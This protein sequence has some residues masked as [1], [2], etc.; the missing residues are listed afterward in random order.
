MWTTFTNWITADTEALLR[1]LEVSDE[2]PRS[3]INDYFMRQIDQ[4]RHHVPPDL[5]RE[6]ER[7]RNFDIVAYVGKSLRNAGFQDAD[8][9][10][11]T[12]DVIVRLL[13]DPGNLVRGWRGQPFLPRTK[14]AIRNAV[15]NLVEKRQRRRRWFPH[16]T[17]EDMDVALH[18]APDGDD[19]TIERFR[20]EV[21]D[22]L[23][24]LALAVLDARLD[25]VDVKSLVGMPELFTPS[26][27]QIKKSVQQVK[28][29]AASFGDDTFR[30]RV[31]KALADEQ[32]TLAKRFGAAAMA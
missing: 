21:Q 25:G 15:L 11:L 23:G 17:P 6:L 12:Q 9:D 14:I 22:Q 27:Y 1:L 20:K 10:P 8:I 32:E 7:A 18:A 13:V 2:F 19:E 3:A 24:D 4:I 31:A 5:Q 16:V 26:H 30:L 28:N 29:L